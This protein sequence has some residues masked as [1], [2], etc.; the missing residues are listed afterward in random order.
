VCD[1]QVV[2]EHEISRFQ[3][4]FQREFFGHH[5]EN[6]KSLYLWGRKWLR[7]Q[8]GI[9]CETLQRTSINIEDDFTVM[10]K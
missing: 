6:I 10:E 3:S 2:Y 1:A 9:T 4:N 8:P 5:V 7:A